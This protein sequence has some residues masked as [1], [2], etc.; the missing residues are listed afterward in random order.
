MSITCVCVEVIGRVV[1]ACTLVPW[2]ELAKTGKLWWPSCPRWGKADFYTLVNCSLWRR[3]KKKLASCVVFF[4]H[5]GKWTTVGTWITD[6]SGIQ[7]VAFSL[8]VKW[9]VI[10]AMTFIMHS[11]FWILSLF[12]FGK[13]VTH[14]DRV[15]HFFTL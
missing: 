8:S 1:C 3:I 13:S 11:V 15:T 6:Q 10:Q 9:S 5:M 2:E 12:S 7:V 4:L 14:I